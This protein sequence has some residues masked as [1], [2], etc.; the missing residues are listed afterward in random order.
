MLQGNSYLIISSILFLLLISFY[1]YKKISKTP[2]IK[3]SSENLSQDIEFYLTNTYPNIK[4]DY[5]ILKKI[6]LLTN[7]KT[8]ENIISQYINYNFKANTQSPVN[9]KSLW[10]SYELDSIP[11]NNKVPKDLKKR[12]ELA[13]KRSKYRCDRCGVILKIER[14]KIYYIKPILEKG[15]FHLEN[16]SV[17]CK[18][19]SNIE[20][21]K[22][23]NETVSDLLI[24]KRLEK[25]FL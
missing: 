12:K 10:T 1:L 18:D 22:K 3:N 21:S 19:C 14:T 16:I 24:T 6:S 13:W 2:K 7:K 11:V 25:R 8:I 5:I 4:F 23:N 20:E 17:I 15:T 9:K